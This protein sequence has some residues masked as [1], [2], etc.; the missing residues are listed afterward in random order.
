MK[1]EESIACHISN[2]LE[3]IQITEMN[4]EKE[5]YNKSKSDTI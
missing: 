3:K 2:N 1:F 4:K 5:T